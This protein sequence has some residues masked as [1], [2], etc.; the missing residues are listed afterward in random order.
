MDRILK[1]FAVL[2]CVISCIFTLYACTK[3][4]ADGRI[5][6]VDAKYGESGVLLIDA[7]QKLT[8]G[9]FNEAIEIFSNYREQT[10]NAND[11]P[12]DNAN[13]SGNLVLEIG[14]GKAY[15]G[16]GDYPNAVKSFLAACDIAPERD[17]IIN[18]LGEAQMQAGAFSDSVESYKLLLG[19][20]SDSITVFGKLEQA[21]RKNRDYA[22]LYQLLTDRL[23]SMDEGSS[24]EKSRCL[25]MLLETAQL[26]KDNALILL[27]IERFKDTPQGFAV[28]TGFEAYNAFLSG[29][30]ETAKSVIF[31]ANSIEALLK[32]AGENGFY[33]GQFNDAGQYQGKGLIIFGN[34]HSNAVCQV[35][36]GEFNANKP[37]GAGLG[38]SGYMDEFEDQRG[39]KTVI[40]ENNYIE[41][42][43]IDGIPDGR[44]VKTYEYFEYSDEALRYSGKIIETAAYKGAMAQGEVWSG[45]YE[46]DPGN[47]KER[48]VSYT[49]HVVAD[50]KPIPFEAAV[51]GKKGSAYE[52]Y[53]KDPAKEAFEASGEECH[54]C[55]FRF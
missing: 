50:G 38:Y 4:G 25:R 8:E 34:N 45:N 6:G 47:M 12:K 49:K 26:T 42:D 27:T 21:L 35:Y 16:A 23:E 39:K 53:Y 19:R 51:R 9:K 2:L 44:V 28:E 22:G 48:N 17:D 10:G 29:D 37:N 30:E 3:S 18:Y 5:P 36:Y 1:H 15:F 20:D 40:L 54:N 11:D 32:S 43:W 31:N 55:I 13:N 41:S 7:Y 33:L 24:P 14:L 52:A 46:Y